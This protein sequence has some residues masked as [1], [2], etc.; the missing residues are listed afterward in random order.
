MAEINSSQ[1]N[2]RFRIY[3]TKSLLNQAKKGYS[4]KIIP[5]IHY[6]LKFSMN[7]KSLLNYKIKIDYNMGKQR[8]NNKGDFSP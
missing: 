7:G 1:T 3:L 4:E 5:I 2:Q 6:F 8:P